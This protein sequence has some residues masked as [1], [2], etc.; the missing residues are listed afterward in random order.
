M[1]HASDRQRLQATSRGPAS[2]TLD[3]LGQR[4]AAWFHDLDAWTEYWDIFHP[5]TRGRFYFGNGADENGLLST[6]LPRHRR[7]RP[8]VAWAL[9]AS[10]SAPA[11]AFSEAIRVPDVAAAVL[12]VEELLAR[13]FAPYFG[14][15]SLQETHDDYLEAMHRF[16]TDTLPAAPERAALVPEGDFRKRTAGRHT[17][18]SDLMWF[19]WAVHIEAAHLLAPHEGAHRRAL[20]MA[21]VATGC[22]ANFTW[23]GHRRTRPEYRP[24][25]ATAAHLRALGLRLAGDIDAARAEVQA[26]Y[27]I[28]EWGHD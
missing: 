1:L 25:D 27:R 21:G 6:Y 2:A 26:L 11:A 3:E 10:R 18:D 8:F 15:P 13:L 23:R 12:D 5:E 20:M 16:A 28:R 14:D 17:L 19:A 9:V 4:Y 7:P 22:A 24:D